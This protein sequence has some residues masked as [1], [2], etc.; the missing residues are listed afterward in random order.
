MTMQQW[1]KLPTAWIREKKGL[2]DLRW[3]SDQGANNLAALMTLVVIAHHAD[4]DSGVAKLTYD[5]LS[6][7]TALSRA[8]VAGGLKVLEEKGILTRQRLG[9]STFQ[10]ADYDP[11]A[12]WGKLPARKLYSEAA[13]HVT[14]FA[15]LT[16]R[17]A[18]E[19][20]ALKLYLLF[21]AMRDN[22]SNLAHISYDGIEDYTGIDR[23][24]IKPGLS[25]LAANGIVHV[26]HVPAAGSDYGIAN[27]YRVA[28]IEAYRHMG[29]MGRG[30]DATNLSD[31]FAV[32]TTRQ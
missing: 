20:H 23:H 14:F 10:L 5:L 26:E 27:A 7:C 12:G 3:T 29:T 32:S 15:G 13:G 22:K 19:L 11:G 6:A 4:E 17:K 18:A 16:L 2:Q 30:L 28:H 31:L 24:R 8:K 21:V 1:V 9:R 25:V